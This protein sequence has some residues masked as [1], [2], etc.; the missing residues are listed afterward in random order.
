M[1]CDTVIPVDHRGDGGTEGL[2]TCQK[3]QEV[4]TRT[5][6]PIGCL[7]IRIA[8]RRKEHGVNSLPVPRPAGQGRVQTRTQASGHCP[9]PAPTAPVLSVEEGSQGPQGLAA[10]RSSIPGGE[11]PGVAPIRPLSGRSSLKTQALGT[12]QGSE[13]HPSCWQLWAQQRRWASFVTAEGGVRLCQA[14]TRC[15]TGPG[16]R[17]GQEASER[18]WGR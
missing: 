11:L 4:D 1:L 18:P 16:W 15:G 6:T 8:Q 13:H 2:V 7:Q 12:L 9:F 14:V 3:S 5:Q 10:G 17:A